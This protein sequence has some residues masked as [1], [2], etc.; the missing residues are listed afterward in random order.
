M[1][2]ESKKAI[3]IAI[4]QGHISK[5]E[6]KKLLCLNTDKLI[7]RTTVYPDGRILNDGPCNPSLLPLLQKVGIDFIHIKRKIYS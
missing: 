2:K 4:S 7:F 3:L 6:A 5:V 1:N